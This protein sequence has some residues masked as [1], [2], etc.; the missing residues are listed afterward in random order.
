MKR[1]SPAATESAHDRVAWI[2]A[3]LLDQKNADAASNTR[4]REIHRFHAADGDACHRMLNAMEPGTYVQPHRH[5][6]PP[7]DEA[8]LVLRGSIGVV[9]FDD[10][11][12]VIESETRAMRAGGPCRG[13][14]LRAGV[15]HT[16]VVLEP[17]TVVYEVKAGPYEPA[18][19]K[20]FATWAPK[21]HAPEATAYLQALESRFAG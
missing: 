20:D 19:D 21:P 17:G 2:G 1:L 18:S 6:H 8:I 4:R 7:K 16:F 3:D 10:D 9:C 13:V 12:R 5:R 11:G 14:D 15:W